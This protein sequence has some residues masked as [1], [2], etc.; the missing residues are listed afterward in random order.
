MAPQTDLTHSGHA[1]VVERLNDIE[2]AIRESEHTS[3]LAGVVREHVL[4]ARSAVVSVDQL[5]ALS[6]APL[7]VSQVEVSDVLMLTLSRWKGRARR[8]TFELALHGHEPRLLADAAMV[9]QAVEG[10]IAWATA[11]SGVGDI[12]VSLQPVNAS[13]DDSGAQVEISVRCPL[14][15]TD[16]LKPERLFERYPE[17]QPDGAGDPELMLARAIAERHGGCVCAATS[18]EERALTFSFIL[19]SE[20]LSVQPPLDAA[21]EKPGAENTGDEGEDE[22]G[23]ALTL[24]RA[25]KVI[26]VAHGDARMARYLRANLEQAGFSAKTALNLT[27]ALKLIELDEPDLVV[28][29]LALP[30]DE[31]R[32]PLARTLARTTAPVLAVGR[33]A[34]PAI[35]VAAL[36]AGAADFIAQPLSVE[37][38]IA[39]VRRALRPQRGQTAEHHQR[40]YTCGDLV[41]DEEQRLVTVGGE[42]MAL[43]KTE[44]RLLRALAQNAGKTLSHEAL[45][46][47]VWGPAYSKEIEFIWVYIRRLRRKIEPDP[48]NPRYILT[49]PGIGYRLGLPAVS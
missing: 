26:V 41:L 25:R 2:R 19:P 18:R 17:P 5:L 9:E 3:G 13:N 22:P 38:A 34:D 49:A 10:L 27:A 43:S 4:R 29:D 31:R 15:P 42:P 45:L 6:Q 48:A 36:D 46:A 30:D 44:Y 28:L 24:A 33:A 12:R 39:R 21:P 23:D 8:H 20:P 40:V 11:H 7:R 1:H 32:D 35:C 14:P 37:E 16:I 47:Q